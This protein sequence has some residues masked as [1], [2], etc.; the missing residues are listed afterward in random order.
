MP[1]NI[2]SEQL[3]QLAVA[4]LT[5]PPTTYYPTNPLATLLRN[6]FAALALR[7]AGQMQ[8]REQFMD[9]LLSADPMRLA[10]LV[11]TPM[12]QEMA[13][14]AGMKT[15]D[16][17]RIREYSQSLRRLLEAIA[18]RWVTGQ[19]TVGTTG[20]TGTTGMTGIPAEELS[21]SPPPLSPLLSIPTGESV[22]IS[23]PVTPTIN[24]PTP[25]WTP[26]PVIPSPMMSGFV[27]T[28]NPMLAQLYPF[29]LF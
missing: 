16:V 17:Q 26:M 18:N 14:R 19:T 28:R 6:L 11:E 23:F 25:T 22:P 2:S 4:A 12:F 15:E 5:S 7:R 29:V 21:Q 13:R 1:I 8:F 27:P 20:T 3:R 10:I 9:W 24:I